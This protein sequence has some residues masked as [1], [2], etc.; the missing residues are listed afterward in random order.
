MISQSIQEEAKLDAMQRHWQIRRAGSSSTSFFEEVNETEDL[1]TLPFQRGSCVPP[2]QT[3]TCEAETE[4]ELWDFQEPVLTP[5]LTPLP[6]PEKG[7]VKLDASSLG[8]LPAQYTIC[9]V[10]PH[11][12]PVVG[13]YIDKRVVPG[14][15]YRVRPLPE[16]GKSPT[17][18]K[19]LFEDKALTL[20]SIGRGY[21]RRFTFEAD[22]NK[23]NDNENYFWSDN[24][25]EGYAFEL[26]VISEGDKFTFFDTN[27][28]AQGTVEVIKLEW[29]S[30]LKLKF[31]ALILKTASKKRANV[32]FTGK[33][34]YYETGVAKLMLLTGTAVSIKA[35]GKAKAEI[36]KVINVNINRHRCYLLPGMQKIHRRVTVRGEEINDVP[37]KYTMTGLESYEIP[38]VG[39]YVDPRVIPGFYYKVRPN[40]RVDHLFG[41]R[42][43]KL[44]SIGMGYAKRLTF[45]PDSLV[46]PDNYLWSD[47]HPDGLGL[48]PR[49][50]HK[51]MKFI[52]KAGDLVLGEAQVFRDDRPQFEERMEKI[53]TPTGYAIQKYIYIDVMCHIR[54][55]RTG[56][57]STEND[58][59]LMR[60]SG[61]A[62]VRKEPRSSEAHVMRVENVG[63]DSQLLLL[64]TQTQTELTFVLKDY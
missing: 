25:P 10:E 44:L 50:V 52:I 59:H 38:V 2:P 64:F 54:L 13:V 45:Q 6:I 41:G 60:V 16:V 17:M 24:R 27:R 49:A 23:L 20:Q 12:L 48:E 18:N 21:A 7:P 39:T 31:L 47:N 30:D 34:E 11:Q 58:E 42:A 36:V 28:E 62:V 56:G 8:D 1:L 9:S 4:E 55:A 61:L 40:D 35:K 3:P 32:K 53:K 33:V 14:F 51:G 22:N 63:L 57:A 26:E 37:T 29:A 15:K 19:C 46:S 43:L 5:K